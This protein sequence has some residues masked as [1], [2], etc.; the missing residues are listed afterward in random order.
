MMIYYYQ[1]IVE[2]SLKE[3]NNRIKIKDEEILK[4]KQKI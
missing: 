1:C 2:Q 4:L 3:T